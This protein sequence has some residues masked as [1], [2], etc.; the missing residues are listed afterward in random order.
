MNKLVADHVRRIAWD[1]DCFTM[2]ALHRKSGVPIADLIKVVEDLVSKKWLVVDAIG[3]RGRR[4]YRVRS[5]AC[6]EVAQVKS[7]EKSMWTTARKLPEFSPTDLVMY[8]NDADI[9]ISEAEAKSYIQTLLK[10]GYLRVVCTAVPG[11]RA[12]RYKLVKDTGPHPPIKRRV[13]VVW[14]QNVD[15]YAHV[16]ELRK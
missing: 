6:G 2:P 4:F 16:P 14:D 1:M 3:V 9:Q 13:Y 12:A 7:P 10:A 15:E 5:K 8:S 11:K